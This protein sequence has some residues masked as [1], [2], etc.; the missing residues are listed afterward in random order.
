MNEPMFFRFLIAAL[1]A[2]L[3]ASAARVGLSPGLAAAA[4]TNLALHFGAGV[5][6]WACLPRRSRVSGKTLALTARIVMA[7]V[8]TALPGGA[9]A[10]AIAL[11]LAYTW[12]VRALTS[13]ASVL[14]ATLDL[15]ITA[16]A[17]QIFQI[18][19]DHS[20]S[21]ALATW[22]AFLTLSVCALIPP[23]WQRRP[24]T[25]ANGSQDLKRALDTAER[26][27]RRLDLFHH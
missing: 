15:A 18:S 22:S 25:H 26:A 3:A 4:G 8:V 7:L 6:A 16:L 19:L 21:F 2:T 13:H 20:G 5:F 9:A 23:S 12:M 24:A 11:S 17:F 10:Y 1:I 27:L 14:S